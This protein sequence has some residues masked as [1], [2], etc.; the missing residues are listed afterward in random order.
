MQRIRQKIIDKDYYISS[1]AED[2]MFDDALE[3]EDV[4]NVILRGIIERK[5]ITDIRGTRYRIEGF[6]LRGERVHVICRFR[7]NSTLV[8]ITTYVVMEEK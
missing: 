6:S 2:E 7:E 4:E 5:L 1:H 8:I 3:R